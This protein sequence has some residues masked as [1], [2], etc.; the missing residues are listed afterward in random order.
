MASA[1]PRPHPNGDNTEYKKIKNICAICEISVRLNKTFCVRLNI[2]LRVG[3]SKLSARHAASVAALL[4]LMG[5]YEKSPEPFQARGSGGGYLLSHFR[6][7]IGVVR[8][9]F[10][11]RN[12]KR[13]IPHAITTL[14]FFSVKPL[15]GGSSISWSVT[16]GLARLSKSSIRFLSFL[17]SNR[18]PRSSGVRRLPR[19][20]VLPLV[21]LSMGLLPQESFRAI[22]TARLNTSP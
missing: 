7:T 12:G 19:L 15:F 18:L 14:V 13:W 10:S 3:F 6:S 2:T 22:S 1:V 11:V 20:G 17:A 16:D 8:L 5:V 21:C 9:N 4:D